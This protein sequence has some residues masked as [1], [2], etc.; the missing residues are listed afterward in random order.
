MSDHVITYGLD[1]KPALRI[2]LDEAR[3]CAVYR[4]PGTS[5]V[6]DENYVFGALLGSAPSLGAVIICN[7]GTLAFSPNGV[8]WE[9]TPGGQERLLWEAVMLTDRWRP[10]TVVTI[11][12]G[13]TADTYVGVVL[14]AVDEAGRRRIAEAFDVNEDEEDDDRDT[15]GFQTV[16]PA[17]RAD[18][19]NSVLQAYPSESEVGP[20]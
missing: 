10:V 17:R 9:I 19:L 15:L 2:P 11:E 13:A 18:D 3:L 5:E 14:G 6:S 7:G 16:M 8:R 4:D 1:G 12:R 20:D